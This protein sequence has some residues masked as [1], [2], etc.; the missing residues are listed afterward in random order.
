MESTDNG[1]NEPRLKFSGGT[2]L[3]KNWMGIFRINP[4][5]KITTQ[6]LFSFYN[7]NC[8]SLLKRTHTLRAL[9]STG[10]HFLEEETFA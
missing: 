3:I 8:E 2:H 9:P 1:I 5:H 6:L 7:Q 10:A 4:F